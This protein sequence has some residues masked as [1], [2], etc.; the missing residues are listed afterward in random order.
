MPFNS[1]KYY[2]PKSMDIIDAIEHLTKCV[3]STANVIE[4]YAAE[5]FGM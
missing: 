2:Q 1:I 4:I 5:L 3:I